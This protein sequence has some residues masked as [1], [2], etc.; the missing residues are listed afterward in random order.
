MR[1][2]I[3]GYKCSKGRAAL[4][5]IFFTLLSPSDKTILRRQAHAAKGGRRFSPDLVRGVSRRCGYGCPQVLLCNPMRD[6]EPF[7][8]S[9]WLSCPHLV[10]AAGRLEA[11]NGVAGMESFLRDTPGGE[12]AW[13]AYHALHARL[14]ISLMP[15]PQREFLR[16]RRRGLYRALCRGGVGGIKYG[17]VGIF[18]K[19]LHL[20][21]ASYLG[22]GRHPASEWLEEHVRRGWTC[23][24]G[25]CAEPDPRPDAQSGH[26]E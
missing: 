12:M 10:R 20:Q 23:K 4:P 1:R 18:V 9:F 26:R 5:S 17:G 3:R 21:L 15:E 6:G 7:P 2:N 11:A 19:C 24:E 22:M 25:A 14:R 8:T 16:G 13:A